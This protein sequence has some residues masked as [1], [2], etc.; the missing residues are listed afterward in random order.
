MALA[1]LDRL[2]PDAA[3]GMLGAI[4]IAAWVVVYTPQ[5]VENAVRRNADAL[6]GA[7]VVVWALGDV[8]N[9]V[10]GLIQPAVL[11]TMIWLAAYFC[12]ADVFLIAQCWYYK[13][14]SLGVA[15]ARERDAGLGKPVAAAE[16]LAAGPPAC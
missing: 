1:L 3:S 4:S 6:S 9:L 14:L 12:L 16:A 8:F 7:F 10:G 5:I 15:T 2:P 11:P 13:G